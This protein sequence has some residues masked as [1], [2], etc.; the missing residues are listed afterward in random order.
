MSVFIAP[1]LCRRC[2]PSSRVVRN[3]TSSTV[4]QASKKHKVVVNPNAMP[5]KEAAHVLKALA[6]NSPF[7]AYEIEIVTK[8]D[9]SAPPLRGRMSLPRDPRKQEEVVLVFAEGE[10]AVEAREAG[11]AFVGGEELIQKVLSGEINPTKVLSTPA[12]LPTIAPKLARFLG[13]KG[14]MPVAKRGTVREDVAEAIAEARGLLDWKGD[15]QGHVRAA[16]A[17]TTFPVTDV[18]AN[19]RHF[20]K[21]V[22]AGQAALASD[23]TSVKRGS[24]ILRINLATTHGPSIELNDL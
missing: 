2:I 3:F 1:S 22:K 20:V 4:S 23:N 6:V 19:V 18:E 21:A 16:V 12:M 10:K 14:L 13:P 15:K 24:P 9:K 11:A 17:R 8:F 5:L 7:S